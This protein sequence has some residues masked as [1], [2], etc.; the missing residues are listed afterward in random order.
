MEITLPDDAGPH[1]LRYVTGAEDRT[2]ARASIAVEAVDA[3]LEAPS[4]VGR[5][6]PGPGRL[7]RPGQ[8]R[9]LTSPSSRA[10]APGGQLSGLR[11]IPARARLVEIRG[12]RRAPEPMRLRYL[13][14][15]SDRTA[16]ERPA[17][18]G[19]RLPRPLRP[20]PGGGQGRPALPGRLGPRPDN[21]RRLPSQS[22]KGRGP[23]G[24]TMP[25]TSIYPRRHPGRNCRAGGQTGR[26]TVGADICRGPAAAIRR[27]RAWQWRFR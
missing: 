10:G 1:E 16:G 18:R 23:R 24:Q 7:D 22:S 25:T 20:V 4:T 17:D 6:R 19:G 8:R 12:A 3:A 21:G 2:L 15:G 26:P 14:G 27:W 11:P 5:R 13:T 9:R